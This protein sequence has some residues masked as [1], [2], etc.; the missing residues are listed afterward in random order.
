MKSLIAAVDFSEDSRRAAC[1]AALVAAEQGAKLE[2]LHVPGRQAASTLRDLLHRHAGAK[3]EAARHARG[4]LAEWADEIGALAGVSVTAHV[5]RGEVLE[6]VT[7]SSRRADLLALGARGWNPLRDMILGSTSERLLGRSHRP[8][9]V[10]R[11][12]AKGPWRRVLVPVDFS[13]HSLAGLDLALRLAPQAEL[14]VLHAFDL[15]FEGKMRYAGVDDGVIRDYRARA[16]REALVE[17]IALLAKVPGGHR[18]IAQA[19]VPG[20]PARAILERSRAMR[21][22]LVV[23]GKHGRSAL[24]EF[25]IGSVTRH[26]LSGSTCDVLVIPESRPIPERASPA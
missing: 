25:V 5:A 9:L 22:D 20:H 18:G 8:V 26:V 15:P 24:E 23:I 2:L 13:R 12:P 3:L 14:T 19:V 6:V 4:L 7:R 21:A 1:R 17:L 11:R 10:V 16:R